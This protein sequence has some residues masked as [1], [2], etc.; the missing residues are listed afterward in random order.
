MV[1]VETHNTDGNGPESDGRKRSAEIALCK[2]E[3][4]GD[5]QSARKRERSTGRVLATC[6]ALLG[7][8]LVVG[9]LLVQRSKAKQFAELQS[10]S[11]ANAAAPPGVD[12]VT[13]RR[14][15]PTQSIPLP[16][17]ARG[18]YESTIY[19]RVSGYVDQWYVDIGDRVTKGQVLATIET[20]DLDAQLQAAQ[21]QLAMSQSEVEVAKANA[22][23]AKTTYERWKE[24]KQGV[25]SEQER[26]EKKA[27]F[28]TGMARVQAALSKV[29]ADQ[30]NV[31]QLS[32]MEAFKRVTAPF[33][34]VITARRID[35]GD[36]VTAGS[37]SNTTSLYTIAQV[38]KIRV[39]VD[40]PQNEAAGMA[41]GV[42]ANLQANEYPDRTFTG[43]IA[44]TA[45][46]IDPATRTLRVEV[47]I[48]N[49]EGLLLPGMYLQVIFDIPQKGLLQVPASA[50]IFRASGP[51]VAVVGNDGAVAFHK[52][53]IAVDNG[54]FVEL[55]S[56][57]AADDQV[58]LNL[59]NQ[60]AEGDKVTATNID[61]ERKIA[62]A[63][64]P[65]EPVANIDPSH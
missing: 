33:D 17:A 8:A 12:V 21:H 32:A 42:D 62:T 56:G 34:G 22:E 37:T 52:V 7:V 6:A 39:F 40:V 5:K 2:L 11:A 64:S 65:D 58:A 14:A 59:S 25:V 15:S 44:R 38:N 41:V 30:S 47:D 57:V 35:I 49:E 53:T 19:A 45:S 36:L 29:S 28:N 63:G 3:R 55:S 26:E 54:D 43:K 13:V 46:A 20:P 10:D 48:D 18:W 1:T 61:A 24:A 50:M 60:I 4:E 9:F 23:F 51:V 31:D 27:E 16:G